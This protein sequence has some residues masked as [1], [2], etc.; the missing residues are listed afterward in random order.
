MDVWT[1][2]AG[3]PV[4]TVTETKSGI[5]V[6]QNRFLRTGDA[7]TEE[8]ETIYPILLTLCKAKG[9]KENILFDTRSMDIP[10]QDLEFFKLNFNHSGIY[11]TNYTPER[12][13]NL[14][15][16]VESGMLDVEDRIG[17]ISDT[18]ALATSGYQ[19]TSAL[20]GLLANLSVETN[21]IVWTEITNRLTTIEHAWMFQPRETR[22]ALRRFRLD[23]VSPRARS[24][25][26]NFT[27]NDDFLLQDYKSIMF[28]AAGMAGDEV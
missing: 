5:H 10:L 26:W 11:R 1:K 9:A 25:G 23:L 16:V 7:T 24:L 2:K 20:L 17:L 19:K 15:H 12:L 27:P 3:Y 6:H 14:A 4:V 28:R 21:G 8:D 13:I 18:G 22:E